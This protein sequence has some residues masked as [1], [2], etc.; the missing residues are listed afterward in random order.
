[1]GKD[2]DLL[3][4]TLAR[5]YGHSSFRPGQR[6][7][8]EIIL[9][10]E[11]ALGLLATG[12]GKSLTYQLPSLILPQLTLVVT[13][14]ISLMID[15]VQKLRQRGRRDATY[16]NSTLRPEEIRQ[17]LQEI[18]AGRYKLLYISPEKLQHTAVIRIL[19]ERGVSLVAIDEAHCISQWGHDFRTDYLRLPEVVE[20]LG[21]PPVLAVTA[22]ATTEVSDEI[23]RL[24]QISPNHLVKQELN[25]TNI[26]YD[27]LDVQSEREKQEHL[28]SLISGLHGSGIV[29]CSTR[30]AVE[31][32]VACC[33]EAGFTSVHGYHGGMEAMERALIQEQFLR[34]KLRVIIATN[35]FGL[36]I[37]K[38]DIR[39]VLHY[40]FPASLEA[41]VQEVGRIGR[42][43]QPGYAGL[44][45]LP[46]DV[47]I[48]Q[49]LIA[50]ETLS[51]DDVERFV[52]LV[53][54]AGERG[55]RI[56]FE[57]LHGILGVGENQMRA[58]FFYAERVG[59][60]EQVVQIR[61]SFQFHSCPVSLPDAVRQITGHLSNIQQSKQEKLGAIVSWLQQES[62]LRQQISG[63]FGEDGAADYDISCCS[64]CGLDR[65]FFCLPTQADVREPVEEWRLEQALAE[66]LGEKMAIGGQK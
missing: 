52:Q 3:I 50:G 47:M 58:L 27:V 56:S 6:E 19:K 36:G 33:R 59:V 30:Q 44:L 53:A 51:G 1:M 45:Y 35:A 29:Y 62:C 4:E 15:Q 65:S 22:T 13:P 46:E 55:G 57:E 2:A 25:R 12:G 34:N 11:N 37:D 5:H 54:A 26:A 60:V 7:L 20:A 38:P 49:R 17:Q 8:I 14:L 40:H 9:K 64:S 31:Q 10:R 66:L 42:D 24:F 18:R 32:V 23:C 43:G 16:I 28:L 63:Y 21:S 61:E 48:H 41:Y 39:F